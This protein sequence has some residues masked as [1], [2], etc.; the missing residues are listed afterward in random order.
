MGEMA[1]KE[2]ANID[3]EHMYMVVMIW[4]HVC[5]CVCVNKCPYICVSSRKTHLRIS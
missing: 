4:S 2:E 5:V 3:D 1:K